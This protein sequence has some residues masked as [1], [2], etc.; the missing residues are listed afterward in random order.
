MVE[1]NLTCGACRADLT[2]EWRVVKVQ[3]EPEEDWKSLV[4][5]GLHPTIILEI[6]P[7]ALAFHY[8]QVQLECKFVQDKL[9]RANK[10]LATS[11][12]ITRRSWSKCSYASRNYSY[13]LLSSRGK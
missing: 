9:K 13:K 3:Q 6:A 12:T 5:A 10:R 7:K 4:L 2:G 8:G 11:R 1:K